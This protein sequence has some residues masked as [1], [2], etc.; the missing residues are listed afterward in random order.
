M[1]Y[2]IR[3]SSFPLTPHHQNQIDICILL[4]D[5]RGETNLYSV[6]R[7]QTH[8]NIEAVS[9][10][11]YSHEHSVHCHPRTDAQVGAYLRLCCGS[12]AYI[13]LFIFVEKK[14]LVRSNLD[15]CAKLLRTT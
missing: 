4:S 8:K 5:Q 6:Q 10:R 9:G 15:R 13:E 2:D 12:T 3:C 1:V 11:E 14:L 7:F